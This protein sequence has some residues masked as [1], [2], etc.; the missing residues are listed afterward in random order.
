[1]ALNSAV[2]K[3]IETDLTRIA[4]IKNIT[5][6]CTLYNLEYTLRYI[7]DFFD[8]FIIETY[9]NNKAIE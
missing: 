8:N 9:R 4:I 3:K 7:F 1:M 5:K 6:M 2:E